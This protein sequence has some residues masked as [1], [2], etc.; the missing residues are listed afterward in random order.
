MYELMVIC[1][2]DLENAE[3]RKAM[4]DVQ[5]RISEVGEVASFDFWGLRDFAYEINHKSRGY[6]SVIE[7]RAEPGA[8]DPVERHLRIADDI[9]RHKLIRLPD[10]EARRRG[11]L[12]A[13]SAH[14]H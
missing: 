5:G 9:V 6:Y 3:A 4:D 13:E 10:D 14:N 7:L 11:L 12:E 2:G 1:D 8:M